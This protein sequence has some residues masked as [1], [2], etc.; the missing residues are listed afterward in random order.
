KLSRLS[1]LYLISATIPTS[2]AMSL[3]SRQAGTCGGMASL[4]QCGSNFPSD[5][6]CPKQTTCMNLNSTEAVSVICCPAG[7]DCSFIQPI[8]CDVGQLNATKHP[9]NQIHMSNTTEIKLPT[10]GD[11]CCPLGYTCNGGMCSTA[12]SSP[13]PSPSSS[14]SPSATGAPSASQTT[15]STPLPTAQA[16]QGFDGKSFAAGFFP[17]I[18]LGALM[19]LGLLWVIKKRRELQNKPRYSGDFGHVSRQIS[20]PIYN[21]MYANRTDFIRRGSNSA[22]PSPNSTTGM[23]VKNGGKVGTGGGGMTPRIK[24]LFSKS[25]RLG[26]SS[27]FAATGTGLPAPALP[28]AVRAGNPHNDPYATP[29]S[30]RTPRRSNSASTRN[31]GM[32]TYTTKSQGKRPIT[33]RSTSTETI[34]VLMPAPSFLSTLE[35]PKAPGMRENRLTQDTTFTKLMERA[36]YEEDSREQVRDW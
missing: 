26:F 8:T 16:K 33:T 5:F 35:P 30:K 31:S 27:N 34:D 14:L 9:D 28:P 2:Q 20:D 10:C 29:K 11:K 15:P 18:I 32:T 23:V 36:G 4:S 22:Q 25:P 13:S 6:C 7:A 17:G 3:L 19:A 21:P 1:L 12:S 24:S